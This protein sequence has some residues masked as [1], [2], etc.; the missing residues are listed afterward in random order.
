[1]SENFIL[2]HIIC[3]ALSFNGLVNCQD[4]LL[5]RS[6]ARPE[7]R[8]HFKSSAVNVRHE[9]LNDVDAKWVSQ[10]T[11]G[12]RTYQII[13]RCKRRSPVGP[14]RLVHIYPA[15]SVQVHFGTK[16][17][18]EQA[19]PVTVNLLEMHAWSISVHAW[20]VRNSLMEAWR[21]IDFKTNRSSTLIL[22]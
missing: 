3:T 9:T 5:A 6:L 19:I 20:L 13:L 4:K 21:M 2:R 1:M 11:C 12:I 8:P 18:S 7:T 22:R 10:A 14:W 16:K 15:N 17:R